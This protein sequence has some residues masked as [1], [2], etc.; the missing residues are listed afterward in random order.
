MTSWRRRDRSRTTSREGRTAARQRVPLATR[1]RAPLAALLALALVALTA[2]AGEG[3]LP[4]QEVTVTVVGSGSVTAAQADISCPTDCV[5]VVPAGT[6]I[7]LTATPA[8]GQ[9]FSGWEGACD[10]VASSCEVLVS[11]PTAVVANF[12]KAPIVVDDLSGSTGGQGCS[13][14]DAITAANTDQEA[15]GCKAGQGA[16]VIELPSGAAVTLTEAHGDASGPSALPSIVTDITIR[17]QG[18][19]IE[20]DSSEL[21]RFFHVA[22]SGSLRLSDLSLIGGDAGDADGGA[23]HVAGGT[24]VGTFVSFESN[25]V[26]NGR[27]G[28]AVFSSGGAVEL[29]DV[30]MTDN[31]APGGGSGS[32]GRGSGVYNADGSLRI[33]RGQLVGNGSFISDERG[34]V[35]SVGFD[36]YAFLEDSEI[37]DNGAL[38]IYNSGE[39][40]LFRV[41]VSLSS[42]EQLGGIVNDGIAFLEEVKLSHNDG[43]LVSGVANTGFMR[44]RGST[45]TD[46]ATVLGFT[47]LRNDGI[48]EVIDSEIA[49]NDSTGGSAVGGGITNTGR[50]TMVDSRVVRNRAAEGGGVRNAGELILIHSVI[51]DNEAI[52]GGGI[53]SSGSVDLLAASLVGGEVGNVAA[54]R[55][56]G[57]Y[58]SGAGETSRLSLEGASAISGNLAGS[59]GG[60]VYADDRFDLGLCA[61]CEVKLNVAETGAG[62]GL[63]ASG[64]GF[65]SIYAPG[66]HDNSPDPIAPGKLLELR[67]SAAEDDAEELR[68]S[69]GTVPAGTVRLNEP[70]LDMPVD[71][72]LGA[73]QYTGLRFIDVSVPQGATVVD[74]RLVFTA[75]A[76]AD[77]RS[78]LLVG[79]ENTVSAAGFTASALDLSSRTRIGTTFWE[80]EPWTEG[81]SGPR[82][83]SPS[84]RNQ[85]Q[86][87]V[88]RPEW[89]T[90]SPLAFVLESATGSGS[91]SSRSAVA[92]DGDPEGSARLWLLYFDPPA[93][94]RRGPTNP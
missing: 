45:V 67:I 52:E 89:V 65:G 31:I 72:S 86:Q 87:L 37:F 43:E 46:H 70:T 40:H 38:G 69:G 71:P 12:E 61:T 35:A 29:T 21:F 42:S 62:G 27:S 25:R 28:G 4:D 48:M 57:V 91:T 83:A 92:Y 9:R 7:Q 66:I 14:V 33:A 15:G 94:E 60:G 75:Q 73:G 93:A 77:E 36:A 30:T 53:Y 88:D 85:V 8:A 22:E 41:D 17:G 55:G 58:V 68:E 81:E 23:I 13:L 84:L 19:T 64:L 3:Q 26:G 63:F 39:M 90:G 82:Q 80:V 79:L 24:L 20:R 47:G 18:A 44:L 1:Q 6:T 56:G 74:A 50:L 11:G 59:D 5:A 78:A 16:D 51:D 54:S 49:D 10:G 2:C 34:V 32:P 76:S